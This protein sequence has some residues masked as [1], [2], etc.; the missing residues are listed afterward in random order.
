MFILL[1]VLLMMSSALFISILASVALNEMLD[2][3]CIEL[4]EKI[5]SLHIQL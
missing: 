1:A 3:E 5:R 4:R 2:R